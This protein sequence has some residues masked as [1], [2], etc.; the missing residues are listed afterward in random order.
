MA[1]VARRFEGVEDG[2][3]MMDGTEIGGSDHRVVALVVGALPCDGQVR[4][5]FLFRSSLGRIRVLSEW[6]P[7]IFIGERKHKSN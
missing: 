7:F 2:R 4:P 3:D 1:P 6:L 5:V